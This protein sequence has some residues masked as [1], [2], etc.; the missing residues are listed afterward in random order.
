MKLLRFHT[1]I[2][3]SFFIALGAIIPLLISSNLPERNL[4]IVQQ[5][6]GPVELIIPEVPEKAEFAGEIFDLRPYDRREKMDRELLAFT[7]MHSNTLQIL[8][9]AN[10]F[11]PQIEP[12]L[13]EEGIPDDFKYLMAIESSMNTMARSPA[14]AAGLWQ[15]MPQTAKELGLEVNDLVDER[16]NI[17][18]STRAACKYLKKAYA[19]Y[20]DWMLVSA[21]YNAGQGRISSQLQKQNV[22]HGMDL[23]LVEETSRYMFRLLAVKELFKSPRKFGFALKNKDL[24][25]AIPYTTEI[26]TT[27]IADLSAYAQ[28]KGIT[29]ARLKDANPW[30]RGTSLPNRTGKKY[31]IRIPLSDKIIYD[32]QQTKAHNKNWVI[33]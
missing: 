2:K 27:P 32:P 10:R 11:F 13:K 33:D 20:G 23:W 24:Y 17:E 7:Y 6:P 8:K 14:G 21:S 12:I 22:D 30:L 28:S 1:V 25:P 18:K 9:K 31:E 19:K 16:Y 29:Y 15:I 26:V 5:E 4:P 3:I